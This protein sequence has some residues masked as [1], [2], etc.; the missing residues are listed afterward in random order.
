M[1]KKLR[2][3]LKEDRIL[4]AP[5]AHDVLTAKIIEKV[6]FE[7]VYMTGYGTSASMLGKP[8]VGLLTL[9]EMA[10]RAS[11]I[12]EAVNIPVIADADTGYGNAVNVMRTVREYEKA[13]VACIQIE[14]QVAPKK[15]GHMLGREIISAEEMVGKIKA[16]C[17][18]RKND[19]LIMARTD[20]RTNY[21]IEE[22]IER[23]KL[24]EEAGADILFI[25]S[26]ETIEEMKMVTSSFNVPVLANMLEHGRTPLLSK[27]ELEEIGYDLAIFCVSSTY[28][29]AKAIM[30]LMIHLKETGGTKDYLDKMITFEEFNKLIGL[31]EIRELER[32]YATGRDIVVEPGK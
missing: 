30:D 29:A 26:V 8:D 17:D 23:G 22:A 28:V 21:G 1:A 18:A 27:D 7:A 13:G 20:A 5:G 9:T 10:R 12:V 3:R 6:G 32:K 14:D 2:E 16:A 25:E 11:N 19:T 24:Y 31:P 4:I 15:C